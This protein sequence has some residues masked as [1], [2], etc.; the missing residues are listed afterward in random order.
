MIDIHCHPLWEVD[1]GAD[2]FEEAVAMCKM[3]AADGITHLVATPHANYSI[4]L[5]P[6]C[7]SPE[8]RGTPICN[9]GSAE[10]PVGL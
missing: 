5:C 2:T 4:F 10:A 6:G 1:D 3:A 8:A 7:E 9:R